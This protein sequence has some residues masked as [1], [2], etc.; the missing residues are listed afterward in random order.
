MAEHQILKLAPDNLEAFDQLFTQLNLKPPGIGKELTP[1]LLKD[2]YSTTELRPFICEFQ[3][4]LGRLDRV[5]R[6]IRGRQTSEAALRQ[7]IEASRSE[8]KLTLARYLFT[9]EEVVD[10]IVRQI[11]V[12]DG[13]KDLDVTQPRFVDAEIAHAIDR[14][15]DF[16]AAILRRL[17]EGQKIYWVSD[18]TSSRIN[19]LVEYPLTTVVLVIKPPGS[20]H[21]FE[22]K[23][24]GRRGRNPFSVAFRRTGNRV[25]PSHRLYGGSMQWLL[26]YEARSASSLSAIYRLVHGAEAPLPGY[27]A[28][29]TVFTIPTRFGPVAAFRY[30]TDPQVFGAEGFQEMRGAM[31]DVVA[32]L[33]K[34]D[35]ENLP[36]VA[37]DM[38]LTAEFLSHMAPA[39]TILSGT[40]SFRVDKLG[41]YLSANGA[42]R[43]FK[44]FLGVDYTR[45]DARQFADTLLEEVLGVYESPDVDYE[46]YASY[47]DAALSV[48]SNRVRADKIFVTLVRQIADV[49]GTLLGVRGHSRGESFVGRNVGLKSVWELGQ[50]KVRLIFMDHDAL[51]LPELENGHFFAEGA[52]PGILLDERHTWGRANPAL[53]PSSLVGYLV[54]IYRIGAK[55]EKQAQTLAETGLKAAYHKTHQAMLNDSRLRAFFSEVFLSRLFDWDKF[56]VGYLNGRSAPWE[57]EIK[58]LFAAKGYEK[59]TF[60][61]YMKAAEKSRGFLE[62]N[63]FL[64]ELH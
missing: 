5:H 17:C 54:S 51:S 38:G 53:F 52:M 31:K 55:L 37:G 60:E 4:K 34:E 63:A 18:A 21:E 22:I 58:K 36:A 24:V 61:Y 20:E 26:R 12:S 19:S 46:D 35:G 8:C 7:F 14:L 57:A 64:Y 33:K 9:P 3:R 62:R 6:K 48:A 10:R 43:Y 23:R 28:R 13:I 47:V 42:E 45:E 59:D 25:P 11:R 32:A 2:G 49:W 29:T 44:D 16:E 56:A 40:S 39:Q 27:V 50:W 15:P 1:A 41:T 30:F